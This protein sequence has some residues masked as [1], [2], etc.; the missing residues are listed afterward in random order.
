METNDRALPARCSCSSSAQGG[1]LAAAT[2]GEDKVG[3]EALTT[4]VAS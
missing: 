3:E 1:W 2:W 4:A